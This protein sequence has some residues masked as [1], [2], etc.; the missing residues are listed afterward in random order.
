MRP[1]MVHQRM[2]FTLYAFDQIVNNAAKW[3]S[4]FGGQKWVP[5]VIRMIIGRG[6]GQGN[7]HS[8]NLEVLFAHIPGLKVVVPSNAYNAKGLLVAAVKDPNPTIFIEHRW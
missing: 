7:Q 2:D 4:M 6:W 8:Q 1:I 5:M 3:Y